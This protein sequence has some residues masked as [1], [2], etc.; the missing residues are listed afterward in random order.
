MLIAS[1]LFGLSLSNKVNW[2]NF[3]LT[4]FYPLLLWVFLVCFTCYALL[5]IRGHSHS[6]PLIRHYVSYL[7]STFA[8][9]RPEHM[10]LWMHAWSGHSSAVKRRALDL[11]VR[12]S[13]PALDEMFV[14]CFSVS[15]T[16]T[17][18][19]KMC[20]L[21]SH[22][23]KNIFTSSHWLV[24]RLVKCVHSRV[25][26]MCSGVVSAKVEIRYDT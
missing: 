23:W 20:L 3:I 10:T 2:T 15:P 11:K 5:H 18:S 21:A 26:V 19:E 25:G 22:A 13:T 14:R 6:P 9:T 4:F 12:G 16:R 17:E 7:I 8:E 24:T 1:K